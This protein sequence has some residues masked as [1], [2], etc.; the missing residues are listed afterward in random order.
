MAD[1]FL[2][3]CLYHNWYPFVAVYMKP[4]HLIFP[5]RR[6]CCF[7]YSFCCFLSSCHCFLQNPLVCLEHVNLDFHYPLRPFLKYLAHHHQLYF[8]S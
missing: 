1:H 4:C 3:N 6:C 7:C 8:A 5:R 2:L